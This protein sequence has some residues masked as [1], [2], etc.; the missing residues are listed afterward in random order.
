LKYRS[1]FKY[2]YISGFLG[3][4]FLGILFLALIPIVKKLFSLEI[5]IFHTFA[6]QKNYQK[7]IGHWNLPLTNLTKDLLQKMKLLLFTSG[8]YGSGED[9]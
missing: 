3:Y 2:G 5:V 8:T 9:F 1:K 7:N 4:D 6:T